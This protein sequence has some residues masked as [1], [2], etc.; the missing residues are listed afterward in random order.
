MLA[1]E[2]AAAN[3]VT[4]DRA[5]EAERGRSCARNRHRSVATARI[6]REQST[7]AVGNLKTHI[8]A[9]VFGFGVDR[10]HESR[11]RVVRREIREVERAAVAIGQRQCAGC[12]YAATTSETR[13]SHRANSGR[14]TRTRDGSGASEP[15]ESEISRGALTDGCG[16]RRAVCRSREHFDRRT[17]SNRECEA[18]SAGS[19]RCGH[20]SRRLIVDP[21]DDVFDR[22]RA[23]R[24]DFVAHDAARERGRPCVNRTSVNTKV[25]RGAIEV[26]PSTQHFHRSRATRVVCDDEAFA[27]TAQRNDDLSCTEIGCEF[28]VDAREHLPHCFHC[29]ILHFAVHHNRAEIDSNRD[30]GGCHDLEVVCIRGVDLDAESVV[31]IRELRRVRDWLIFA[32]KRN[33]VRRA[34]NFDAEVH[35]AVAHEDASSVVDRRECSRKSKLIQL[36]AGDLARHVRAADTELCCTEAAS[37]VCNDQRTCTA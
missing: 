6:A 10:A 20:R 28:R 1:I 15:K 9:V 2:I 22:R 23:W 27:I 16:K 11:D 31:E 35:N 36:R 19:D 8:N 18:C 24:C 12:T 25:L 21:C 4:R 32:T 14:H 17:T 30:A 3:E 29:F 34:I 26:R 13:Q 33:V 7:A 5:R 37:N